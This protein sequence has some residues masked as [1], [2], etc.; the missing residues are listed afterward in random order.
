LLCFVEKW[1]KIHTGKVASMVKPMRLKISQ[2]EPV[3]PLFK[4]SNTEIVM[5]PPPKMEMIKESI[6]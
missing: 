1:K 2:K 3:N 5:R 4:I 6:K